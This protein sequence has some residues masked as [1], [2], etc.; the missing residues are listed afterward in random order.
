MWVG[1]AQALPLQPA[2]MNANQSSGLGSLGSDVT[3]P[4]ACTEMLIN[5][6]FE[7]GATGWTQTSAGGYDLISQFNPHAGEWGAYLAG[8]HH[9]DDR[10]S[11][12]VT[13]AAP[14]GGGQSTITLRFWWSLETEEPGGVFDSLTAAL[15]RTDGA[16][17]ATLLTID[18]TA[19]ATVWDE[20]VLDLSAY[21][22]QTVV[23]RFAATSNGVN[24]TDFYVDDVSL[25]TC[26]SSMTPTATATASPAM[27]ATPSPTPT[28]TPQVID[29]RWLFL[30][31]VIKNEPR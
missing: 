28:G 13:L 4:T 3:S 1:L 14:T 2:G 22:G 10:L 9:A 21:A 25:E 8:E 27:T 24:L 11:Q 29:R 12:V 31:V 15:L 19:P 20:A 6:D 30:P 23:L 7:A 16:L 26:A 18:N 17:L 5:G